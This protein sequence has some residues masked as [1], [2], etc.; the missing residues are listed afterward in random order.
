MGQPC[1]TNTTEIYI[2]FI[3]REQTVITEFV[4]CPNTVHDIGRWSGLIIFDNGSFDTFADGTHALYFG[5]NVVYKCGADGALSNNCTLRGGETHSWSAPDRAAEN[6]RLEGIAFEG[7]TQ[8]GFYL[9]DGGDV[10]FKDCLIKNTEPEFSVVYMEYNAPVN[11]SIPKLRVLFEDTVFEGNRQSPDP[12]NAT[13]YGLISI[14][15]P[16]NEAVFNNCTFIN[17]EYGG[18]IMANGN[19]S[20]GNAIYSDGGKVAIADSCFINN[21][22]AGFAPVQ[23]YG[24]GTEFSSS[25]N[26]ITEDD[27]LFCNFIGVVAAA[28][29]NAS[30]DEATCYE[31]EKLSCESSPS[32]SGSS[33][34]GKSS[35]SSKSSGPSHS[36][37]PS[38]PSS[39]G[40]SSKSSGS[41]PSSSGSSS[42]GKSSKSSKSSGSSPSSSGSSPSGS[43][44]S[45]KSSKSA[46]SSWSYST[47]S[48]K[49]RRHLS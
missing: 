44:S 45:G 37:S 30:L 41:S 40:K 18:V 1:Y 22:F 9:F 21:T 8:D 16:D 29:A 4:L 24:N 48:S 7:A 19:V 20:D 14:I 11:S 6:V 46:K 15:G 43:S 26:F 32:S 42:S 33:S 25:G 17:N 5:T 31:A 2:D 38:G 27:D 10:T 28:A 39:S 35:K 23:I 34:S 49:S 12:G 36:P 3:Q 13:T 47:K